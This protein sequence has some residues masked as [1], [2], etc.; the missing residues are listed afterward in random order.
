MGTSEITK[1]SPFLYKDLEDPFSTKQTILSEGGFYN[2]E[3]NRLIN[4]YVRSILEWSPKLGEHRFNILTGTEIKTTD[5]RIRSMDGYGISYDLGLL[6]KTDPRVVDYL[7]QKQE[8]YFAVEK[9]YDRYRGNFFR[10]AYS[11]KKKYLLNGSFRYDGSNQL[12]SDAAA[13][14]L[15]SYNVS[16]GWNASEENF[17]KNSKVVNYLKLKTTYGLT[18]TLPPDTS[19]QLKLFS[20][21]KQHIEQEETESSIAIRDLENQDLTWEKLYEWNLGFE[22]GLW[23]DR[24]YTEINYYKRKSKDLIDI[25]ETPGIGGIRLKRGNIGDLEAQ[26]VEVTLKTKNLDVNDFKWNTQFTFNYYT[27]KITRLEAHYRI[28]DVIGAAGGALLGGPQR[29]I[30]SIPFAGL[31]SQGIPTFYDNKGNVVTDINLQKRDDIR[32]WLRYEGPVAPKY[33]GGIINR[34][35]YKNWGLSVNLI[36]KAGNKIRLDNLYSIARNSIQ[37]SFTDVQA[38][39]KEFLNRWRVPGDENFTSIPAFPSKDV[40]HFNYDGDDAY[41]LY[42]SSTVRVA[43]GDFI[44][45]KDISLSYQL[46]SDWL[47]N[48]AIDSARLSFS[49]NNI[50]LIY[51]DKKLN[52]A[53]PEFFNAG[54]VAL[55]VQRTYTF[56]LNVNF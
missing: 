46:P 45:L 20:E 24:I 41:A 28:A 44:R 26:G 23:N 14:W 53:D 19:A 54:G 10:G 15:P 43:K 17:L 38:Y 31:N 42:N 6:V 21:L 39:P 40:W 25:I 3:G 37:P 56:S 22:L 51:S 30:Y 35:R 18:G 47:K 16:A 1:A 4:Y 34:F 55:P 2:T 5:R 32:S 13:R 52:G 49:A 11:F 12:G 33:Q 8:Q 9:T 36:Y 29:G 50:W 7:R 48:V 27:D